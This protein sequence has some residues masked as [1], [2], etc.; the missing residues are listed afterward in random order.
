MMPKTVTI[1]IDGRRIPSLGSLHGLLE[2]LSWCWSW[3]PGISKPKL[4]R[5]INIYGGA[6]LEDYARSIGH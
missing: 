4:Y 1:E 6:D 2:K 3:N 5:V